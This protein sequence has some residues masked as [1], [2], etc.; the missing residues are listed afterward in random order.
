MNE[1][2][3]QVRWVVAIGQKMWRCVKVNNVPPNGSPCCVLNLN[4]NIV[5]SSCQEA[6]E[7]YNGDEHA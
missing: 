5:K 3:T 2:K 4:E 6:C 1:G 7:K